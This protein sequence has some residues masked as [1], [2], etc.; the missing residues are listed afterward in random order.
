MFN[1]GFQDGRIGSEGKTT[2]GSR[3]TLSITEGSHRGELI[4]CRVGE[5]FLMLR[6]LEGEST[7]TE[8]HRFERPDLPVTLQVGVVA[9]AWM[10]P[11]NLHAR[12]EFVRFRT[13]AGEDDCE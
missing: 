12:F 1:V 5:R 3:S 7:F 10:S 4:L 11:S 2:V 8:T 9:S 13:P 6:K